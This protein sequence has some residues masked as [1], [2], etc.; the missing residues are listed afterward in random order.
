MK[1]YCPVY[2]EKSPGVF[3]H[4]DN[5]SEA[6]KEW[7]IARAQRQALQKIEAQA[8][9]KMA[10]EAKKSASKCFMKPQETV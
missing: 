3:T 6:E 4:F 10:R 9:R 7:V 2:Y 8:R 1:I 5:L